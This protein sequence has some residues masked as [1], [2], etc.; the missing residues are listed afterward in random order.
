VMSI[1]DAHPNPEFAWYDRGR[2]S[3]KSPKSTHTAQ[4]RVE[5]LILPGI[6]SSLEPRHSTG[7]KDASR[8]EGQW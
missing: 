7:N 3:P 2:K 4:A 8:T 6:N 5:P 1:A